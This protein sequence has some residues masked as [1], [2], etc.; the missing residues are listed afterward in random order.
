MKKLV[1]LLFSAFY[2]T[3]VIANPNR[4]TYSSQ[5]NYKTAGD[6]L[7]NVV[8]KPWSY[9]ENFEDRELGAWAS[10]PHWQDIAYDQNFRVNE[11]IPG[12]PNISIVQKVTPYTSVDNYAGA[13]KLLDMYLVPGSTVSFRYYLKTNQ[14]AEFYK[15]R[16][17]AGKYGKIDF[18][19]PDPETN[20]WVW[21]TVSFDDFVRQNPGIAGNTKVK[22][23]AL[24]FLTKIS[25]ADPAMPIYLGLDDI[26]FKGGRA[27]V[28]QFAQPTMYKLPEF[29]P[30][31]PKNHYYGGD[32]FNLSGSWPL[33]AKEVAVEIVSYT[34]ATKSVYKGRLAKN[35]DLW[36]LKPLKLSFPDGLYLGKLVAYGDGSSELS[37]T[38]FTIHIAPKNIAGKHPRLLFDADKKKW[39][40]ERFKEERFKKVY[41]DILKNAKIQREQIPISS[42]VF[43]LD[44][45]PDE[46]WLPTWDAWGSH[47]LNTT[48]ALR[49]NSMAYTFHGDHEAGEYVKNMLV[50][51][52]GW[53]N[54]THPWQTKRGRFAE[55]RTGDWSHRLAEAYDL[56][57][58]LMS[59][60]E[61]TKIR[62][63]LMKNIVEGVHRTY[64]Y[65]DNVTGKTSNWIAMTVGGSLMNM[66][67]M[68]GDGPETENLEPYFTGAMMKFY[69]FIN[70]VTDSKDGAWGEGLGY[71]G[72]SFS[73]MSYSVPSLKNVFNID[74][75]K[76]LVGTYNEYI[77]A[78]LIKNRQFFHFGDNSHA[79]V[80]ITDWAFLLNMQKEPRLGWFYNYL[81][82]KENF[83]DVLYDTKNVQQDSPFDE[84]PDKIFHEVGTT[85]F[86]SGWEKDD[87]SF[88]MRTGAFYNHQHLDQGSFWL[89]DHG[90][91]F[92]E[93]RKGSSYYEDPLY[94]SWFIQPISHSTILVNGNHQSQRVG[95]ELRFAPGFDDH[96]F[97]A[98]SLDGKD[99][100]FSSGDIGR[101][102]WGQV[103]SIKRNVL[104][105]KPRTLLM[106]DVAEPGSKDADVT[107]LYQTAYLEDINAGQH[108]SKI[109]KE[110][111][112]L[113]I[114][115]LAPK[116]IDAKAV[117]TPHYLNTL[118]KD[119]PLTKEGMLTVTA[120]TSGNP[121]VMANLLTT[122]TAEVAPNVT[123][124]TGDGFVTGV[125][126][127]K[128]FAF[129]TRPGSLYIVE[130]IE[131][132]A[133]AI[134]WSDHRT[135]V[136]M[137]TTFRK[138]GVLV[139]ESDTPL[140]FELSADSLKYY[141]NNSNSGELRI[142]TGA[143]P[144]SITINGSSTKNFIYDNKSKVI[145]IEV[146]KGEG[147]VIIK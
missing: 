18:T 108:I 2:F 66:A 133:L 93:E 26:T 91:N 12:D 123:S 15:I 128:K 102:Y 138:N 97:I 7:E 86:K 62:K 24:A 94:Q 4:I 107:L 63:A 116:L 134:T 146:P 115:H 10:Y 103:K 28:F 119:K 76:P 50:T 14:Y 95:D 126:S 82:L 87:L 113:N 83:E 17:A 142:G 112:S 65:D 48:E 33:A 79:I 22:I 49:W 84:N 46:D 117:E 75:S 81:K 39:I 9:S 111:F 1:T 53:P 69:M 29:E 42:L 21:V 51:L 38:E 144:S 136:A 35:G 114:M 34:D 72:Y 77:W 45:F 141:R 89:A 122:T 30:Y 13:Q 130:N 60:D 74:V 143:R 57:Y 5:L 106:L 135:F 61:R 137:A 90:V 78:G 16:F 68:F 25:N 92:I 59:P 124:E 23:Y 109:T 40:D 11:I 132:D 3:I 41:D 85:V 88:V 98:E 36:V 129:T 55:H 125:A 139:A 104:F 140:T 67:A 105:L 118:K 96:A 44:Q 80:P 70:R 58:D 147:I 145:T 37:N 73:N 110:G 64:V 56:T 101:L 20:K 100:A 47:V 99:A 19:I 31:I 71:N 27:T 120:R 54:W 127:D 52:A 6:T 32:I 121:L 8:V 43:D 131:T